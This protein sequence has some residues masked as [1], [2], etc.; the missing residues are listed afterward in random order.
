MGKFECPHVGRD[1]T[2]SKAERFIRQRSTPTANRAHRP[3]RRE[4]PPNATDREDARPLRLMPPDGS[5]GE[6]IAAGE[7]GDCEPPDAAGYKTEESEKPGLCFHVFCMYVQT[8]D[9]MMMGTCLIGANQRQV[10]CAL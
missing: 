6:M 1:S 3:K 7:Q 10:S 5:D 2:Q 4:R 8:I 9:L